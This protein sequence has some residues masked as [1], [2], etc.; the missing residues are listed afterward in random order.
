MAERTIRM[1][2]TLCP[3]CQHPLDACTPPFGLD[4]PSPGDLS[5]CI[6]C[7]G[8]LEIAPDLKMQA[9]E[10]SKLLHIRMIDPEGFKL[11]MTMRQAVLKVRQN[12]ANGGDRP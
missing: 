3:Y 6:Q 7:G 4:S 11:L 9:L 1:P 5:I 8:F 10:E 2:E 12:H